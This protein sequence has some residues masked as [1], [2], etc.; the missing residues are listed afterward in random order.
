[1]MT[2]MQQLPPRVELKPYFRVL[3]DVVEE[4]GPTLRWDELFGNDHPVEIDV[5]CGRGLFLFHAG[6]DHPERNYLGVEVDYKEARRAALRFQKRSLPNVRIFGGDVFRLFSKMLIPG[7]VDAIHVYFPD[8]WWKRKHRRRRV[9]NDTFVDLAARLLKPDG[10]LHSWTDVEEYFRV[11]SALM[12]NH[13]EF[14]TLP[15]PP[16]RP[17]RDDQD[18]Q[19]SYER[20]KRQLGLPIFRGEWRRRDT[21]SDPSAG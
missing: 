13:P 17:P 2:S 3:D 21:D 9:F 4:F 19:T 8:P 15:T 18:Y 16:E 5:G 12:D 7:S 11:I 14:E 1:M 6:Q 20:K 10:R